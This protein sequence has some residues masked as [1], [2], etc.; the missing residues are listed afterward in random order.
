MRVLFVDVGQGTCQIVLLGEGRAIVIDA[1]AHPGVAHRI[2][3]L[4]KIHTIELLAVSHSH[5]DHAGGAVKNKKNRNNRTARSKETCATGILVDFQESI[6]QIGFVQDSNFLKSKFGRYVVKLLNDK[7]LSENQ[8]VRLER[9]AHYRPLWPTDATS[10]SD[11]VLACVSPTAAGSIVANSNNNVNAAS[12][13][14]ELR[15]LE[16]R[17]IFTGDSEYAQWDS[18]IE[19]RKA[20]GIDEPIH[21]VAMSMPHHGG[22]MDGSADDLARFAN[23]TTDAE[24]VVFSVGTANGHG[25]PRSE[26]ITA[27]R[28]SGAHVICTQITHRCC[29]SLESVRPSVAGSLTIP[30]RSSSK[31][32]YNDRYKQKGAKRIRARRSRNVACAGSIEARLTDDGIEVLG[33]E[34]HSQ[35]VDRLV[36][37][38]HEPLC[39]I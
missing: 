30:C 17:V 22:L 28:G 14:I 8:L 33:L 23:Q 1:G 26:V 21:C 18:L 7:K 5:V 19:H 13:I 15:H 3:K 20:N 35:G 38:G 29:S 27:M 4:N 12:A 10:D 34:K 36:A 24:V 32:D 16:D 37:D 2:L 11:T 6:R 9:T 25:H 39:R 31:P